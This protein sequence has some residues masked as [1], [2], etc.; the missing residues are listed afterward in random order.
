M[1]K[2]PNDQMNHTG[3]YFNSTDKHSIKTLKA[4]T[5]FHFASFTLRFNLAHGN[6]IHTY[7]FALLHPFNLANHRLAQ[8]DE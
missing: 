6:I 7:I 8:G 1:G 4:F 5:S 2:N 3:N